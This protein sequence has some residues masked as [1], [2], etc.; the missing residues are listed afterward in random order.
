M[1]V[2]LPIVT[3]A[4]VTATNGQFI[5]AV[6]AVFLYFIVIASITS[7]IPGLEV[8]GASALPGWLAFLILLGTGFIVIVW[9]YSRR[10]AAGCR[11]FL[12][13]AILL[14]T[15]LFAVTPYRAIISQLYPQAP[16]GQQVPVVL[17]FDTAKPASRGR[18]FPEKHKVHVTIPLLASGIAE[19]TEVIAG[20][21]IVHIQAPGGLEWSSGWQASGE[22]F[23]PNIHHDQTT[24]T[25]DDD[26]FERV[27]SSTVNVHIT[28]RWRLGTRARQPVSSPKPLDFLF[29][30][31]ADARFPLLRLTDT[32]SRA[33]FPSSLR[34]N[35]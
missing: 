30:T 13:A 20:G 15:I 21:R 5:L 23:L 18:G 32:P 24:L 31:R 33:S 16:P 10:I 19:D 22:F 3:L 6:L 35:S 14:A 7:R 34:L 2:I 1:F 9:Q 11:V 4:T 25:I 12:L 27:K 8:I 17:A 29:Q 28:M 26:F